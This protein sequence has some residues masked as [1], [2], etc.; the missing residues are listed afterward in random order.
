MTWYYVDSTNNLTCLKYKMQQQP[1]I[2][3][4]YTG[5][6]KLLFKIKKTIKQ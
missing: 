4:T 2:Q 5:N 6:C 3:Y 1:L